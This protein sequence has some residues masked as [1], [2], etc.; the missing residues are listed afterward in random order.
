MVI[1]Q[2]SAIQRKTQ[3]EV[4][5]EPSLTIP[6]QS[7]TVRDIL[8]RFTRGMMIPD[9]AQP[10]YFDG[11]EDFDAVDPRLEK[12]FDLSDVSRL[13]ADNQEFIQASVDAQKTAQSAQKADKKEE[14]NEVEPIPP[15]QP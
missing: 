4:N 15:N 9:S 8:E 14:A 1:N 3:G 5:N 12:D 10:H 7:L 6:N 13:M 2:F 11:E